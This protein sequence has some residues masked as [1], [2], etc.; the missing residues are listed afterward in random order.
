MFESSRNF[1]IAMPTFPKLSKLLGNDAYEK[2]FLLFDF[3]LQR[4]S[5]EAQSKTSSG[6]AFLPLK[7]I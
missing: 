4:A 1:N 5:R 3:L 7:S 2:V 6:N